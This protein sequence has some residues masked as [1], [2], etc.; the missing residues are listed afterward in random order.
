MSKQSNSSL[1]KTP[2][3]LPASQQAL[4]CYGI[5]TATCCMVFYPNRAWDPAVSSVDGRWGRAWQVLG[6]PFPIRFGMQGSTCSW[7][8]VRAMWEYHRVWRL[9]S[10]TGQ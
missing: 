8:G 2:V 7:S 10:N 4:L 9:Q 6:T 5:A 1:A 3:L